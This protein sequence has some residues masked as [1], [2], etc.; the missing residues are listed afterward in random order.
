MAYVF[1]YSIPIR[2]LNTPITSACTEEKMNIQYSFSTSIN[3]L[4][5]PPTR[6]RQDSCVLS[7]PSF[8]FAT[9][10]SQIYRGLQKTWK[11]ETGSRR[12][13]TVLSCLQLSSHHRHRQGKTIL[14]CLDPVSSLQ[15]F[16]LK[17]IEDYW[18]LGNCLVLSAVVFTPPM[19]TRQDSFV[20]SMSAL[21]N[22]L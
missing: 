19:R 18:K 12:D 21:W 4:L 16:S 10:Q 6:T 9:V 7:R 20:L 17:Y 13:K 1:L 8:Q 3:S 2:S 22:K 14:S 15:L 5:T 11:L